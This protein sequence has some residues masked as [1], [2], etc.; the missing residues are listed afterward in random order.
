MSR[1]K[2]HSAADSAAAVCSVSGC[3]R[4]VWAR[5][6]CRLHYERWREH[7]DPIATKTRVRKVP[8]RCTVD[9]CSEPSVAHGWCKRH[10]NQRY[11][12]RV[13]KIAKRVPRKV[14]AC[15]ILGCEEEA[16]ARGWCN[17]HYARWR[18]HGDPTVLRERRLCTFP[19][20]TDKH[21]A[22]GFC[23][24]HLWRWSRHGDPTVVHRAPAGSGWLT[25]DGYRYRTVNGKRTSEHRLI[26]EQHLGRELLKHESVH[27]KNGA[28]DDNR[29]ANL[30]VW[31]TWQPSGQRVEDK[32]AWAKELLAL[33][34]SKADQVV[35][36]KEI[37]ESHEPAHALV[38]FAEEI[39][40]RHKPK[41]PVRWIA[42]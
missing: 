17:K 1:R 25:E 39:V 27:H 42:G 36:A 28:R 10:Y 22:R 35:R 12:Q 4:K 20:C 2:E 16:K 9:A 38:A 7:G 14:V 26:M 11:R 30:E 29:L 5:G 19:G 15:S 34:E 8:A 24:K 31:S 23:A 21:S 6:W 13:P 41:P 18:R 32:V 37:L 40:A 33:Y 3:D